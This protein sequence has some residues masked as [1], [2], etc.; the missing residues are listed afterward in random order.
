MRQVIPRVDP[1]PSRLSYRFQRLMLTPVY[2]RDRK[3]VV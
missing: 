2:R 3:S 1:A